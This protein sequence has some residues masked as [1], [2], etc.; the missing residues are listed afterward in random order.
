MNFSNYQEIIEFMIANLVQLP[1]KM[2]LT[3]YLRHNFGATSSLLYVAS[4]LRQILEHGN[5][6]QNMYFAISQLQINES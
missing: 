4:D 3:I 2:L 6:T 5:L 1:G